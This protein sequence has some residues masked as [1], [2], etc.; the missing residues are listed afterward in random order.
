[1]FINAN[2]YSILLVWNIFKTAVD[3]TYIECYKSNWFK[4]IIIFVLVKIL[5]S[6]SIIAP[7]NSSVIFRCL[8]RYDVPQ[9][10]LVENN[11]EDAKARGGTPK[12]AY[13]ATNKSTLPPKKIPEKISGMLKWALG[14]LILPSFLDVA[15]EPN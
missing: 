13:F 2:D 1:M 15:T 9:D 3:A 10:Q 4:N 7:S 6:T 12:I 8:N 5:C 14:T 11:W